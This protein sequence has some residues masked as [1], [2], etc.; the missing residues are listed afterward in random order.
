MMIKHLLIICA[1]LVLIIFIISPNRTI[2]GL[3]SDDSIITYVQLEPEYVQIEKNEELILGITLIKLRDDERKDVTVSLFLKGE[4]SRELLL[5]ETVALETKVSLIVKPRIPNNLDIKDDSITLEVEVKDTESG[6]IL[7][8]TTQRI[9]IN[10]EFY[11]LLNEDSML[12]LLI[13]G[14]MII[15]G[16]IIR[17]ILA[18]DKISYSRGE[19]DSF[20]KN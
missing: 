3:F 7:S 14:A 2:H 5:S 12:Y 16:I 15:I 17:I 8:T 11:I 10:D 1:L 13:I 4:D 19:N 9:I 20:K 6:K 18:K